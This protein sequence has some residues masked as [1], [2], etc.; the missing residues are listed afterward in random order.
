MNTNFGRLHGER[1]VASSYAKL[2]SE[3]TNNMKMLGLGHGGG[4]E[5]LEEGNF[6]SLGKMGEQGLYF[7][8]ILEIVV[9]ANF[10]CKLG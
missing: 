5:T 7:K 8:E 10:S 2:G 3:G 4:L 6:D 9:G 1:V